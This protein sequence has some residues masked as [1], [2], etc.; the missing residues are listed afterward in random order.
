ML[1][2]RWH[3]EDYQHFTITRARDGFVPVDPKW[4]QSWEDQGSTS[5]YYYPT[6]LVGKARPRFPLPTN[7]ILGAA[8][9]DLRPFMEERTDR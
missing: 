8:D 1:G 5:L 4:F 3:H 2:T 9:D 7:V 6:N